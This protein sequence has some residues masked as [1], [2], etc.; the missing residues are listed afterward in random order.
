MWV[1]KTRLKNR[2]TEVKIPACSF[3]SCVTL[4]KILNSTEPVPLPVK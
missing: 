1:K 3:S 4:G 2:R